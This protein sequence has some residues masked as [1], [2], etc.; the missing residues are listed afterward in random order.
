VVRGVTDGKQVQIRSG[1][2]EGEL[3]LTKYKD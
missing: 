1:L 2:T 3:V